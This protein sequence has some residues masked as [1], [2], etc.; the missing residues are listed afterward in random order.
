MVVEVSSL[1]MV[2][3]EEGWHHLPSTMVEAICWAGM[4]W[5]ANEGIDVVVVR[6][7]ATITHA[8]VGIVEV[9]I[10]KDDA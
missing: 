5:M 10:V 1:A 3:V 6:E 7:G 2:M 4:Y 9:A 8:F